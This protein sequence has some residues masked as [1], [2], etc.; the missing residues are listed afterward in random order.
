MTI[1]TLPPSRNLELASLHYAP[2][3]RTEG[4]EFDLTSAFRVI[5]RRLGTI[6]VLIV[7]LMSV[8]APLILEREPAYR[9]ITRLMIHSPLATALSTQEPGASDRL[10]LAAETERLLSRSAAERVIHDL[11]LDTRPEFNPALR[12]VSWLAKLRGFIRELIGGPKATPARERQTESVIREY[13]TALRV[14]RDGPSNVI[15]IGFEATDP[16]L[17]AAVPNRLL[18]IYLEERK[19][20]LRHRFGA[21]QDW[22]DQSIAEQKK[23]IADARRA[24]I[25]FQQA[26][27]LTLSAEADGERLKELID[28]KAKLEKIEQTRRE[29]EAA[30]ASL[31][32]NDDIPSAI[33]TVD[34]PDNI[35]SLETTLQEQRAELSA[36]LKTYSSSSQVVDG[37]RVR[38]R[39]SQTDLHLA[40]NRHLA[41]TRD[42]LTA[43]DREA[44]VIRSEYETARAELSRV[45][46]ARNESAKLE[47]AIDVE[48]ATF[49]KLEAQRRSLA[50]LA[51]LPAAE[52]EVLS[53]AVV[54][55]SPQG[56]SRLFYLAAALFAA[57]SIAIT[58][59]VV[60]EMMDSSIRSFDQIAGLAHVAPA[61]LLPYVA[62]K[63]DT[64][65]SIIFKQKY[66]GNFL[67]AVRYAIL[68]LERSNGGK[69]P[70]SLLITSAANGEGKS[71][72][73]AALA[74]ELAASGRAVLLVDG[75]PKGGSLA[76]YF[77]TARTQQGLTEFLHGEAELGDVLHRH[78]AA[79]IDFIP[80]GK[81]GLMQIFPSRM[82][83]IF[84][85]AQR[86][87]QIVIIDSPALLTSTETIRM[88][89][90]CAR[91]LL[92][93][94][95]GKTR[96]RTVELCIQHT[97]TSTIGQISVLMNKVVPRRQMLY[98]FSD[99]A[100]FVRR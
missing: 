18:A 57:I 33:S 26:V 46:A 13:F 47:R 74:V 78:P 75:D 90:V 2:S 5:R 34:V 53:P 11:A 27:G 89:A 17:A 37:M 60:I 88:T 69:F 9:A 58:A 93:A 45:A 64:L 59:A 55:L 38:V 72:V 77:G 23:R 3:Y 95:W 70:G 56:Q 22:L 81:P 97:R 71:F 1:S 67:H 66:D 96:R 41:T 36:A 20:S 32:A 79:G 63:R 49:D 50:G 43:I 39:K 83:E 68:C 40:I 48:Q 99:S 15:E 19:N 80:A 61:G 98:D 25:A 92:V 76:S 6:A 73:A 12:K 24:A 42:R 35:K 10:D 84:T 62:L 52:I 87:D 91:T 86:N 100:M 85:H 8:A 44:A 65:R 29:M 82:A 4:A 21:A 14:W 30:I 16:E 28:L 94:Q 54:P 7:L 31:E 51:K